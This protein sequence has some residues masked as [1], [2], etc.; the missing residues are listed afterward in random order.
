VSIAPYELLAGVSLDLLLGDPRWFP[1]PVRGF[2]WL[3]THL[4]RFWRASYHALPVL[5][6]SE[7]PASA[8]TGGAAGPGCGSTILQHPASATR[9]TRWAGICF[10]IS[11]VAIA[12]AIV[13]TTLPWLN[14][15]WIW[16]LLALRDLDLEATNVWSALE[17]GD[18]E[19][20]R[21]K[22]A[23]IVGRDT[24]HL[25]EPEI[26]R[27]A[28]E[29]I[30][31]NLSDAV[32]A[33]LFYLAIGGP[34]GMA[35]YKA[36]NTLDSMVGYRDERYAEFGWASARLDDV[37]NFVPARLTAVLVWS[38]A[39]LLG[40]DA[41]RSWRITLRDAASQ[42]SPNSGYPEAAVAGALGIRLGGVNFY[43]GA[44]SEKPYLGDALKPL[45][46]RAFQATRALLYASS[47][48]MLLAVYGVALL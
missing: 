22:L 2:G 10:T 15:F 46:R 27:A 7:L 37:A 13:W 3:A 45:D 42:P 20:A 11:A 26:L 25:D 4:E 38:C 14:I 1:H 32:I 12:C 24:A 36:I 39:L 17:R 9:R 33:P 21:R 16:I 48:L 47:A 18:M 29:T 5:Q 41:R 8:P 19:E 40:Y 44:R 30:A 31:E 34:V 6:H 43:R 28:I 23:L 35:A